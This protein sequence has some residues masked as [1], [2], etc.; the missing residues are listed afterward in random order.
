MFCKIFHFVTKLTR[1]TAKAKEHIKCPKPDTSMMRCQKYFYREAFQSFNNTRALAKTILQSWFSTSLSIVLMTSWKYELIQGHP[2][3][4]VPWNL[5][6]FCNIP[7]FALAHS[8]NQDL[9]CTTCNFESHIGSDFILVLLALDFRDKD[10][11][12]CSAQFSETYICLC[13]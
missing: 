1:L 3:P 7:P 6:P 12:V 2:N 9:R 10:Q 11:V 13:W 5:S 8:R 4:I